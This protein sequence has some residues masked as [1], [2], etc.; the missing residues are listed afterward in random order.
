MKSRF[1]N[2]FNDCIHWE[3]NSVIFLELFSQEHKFEK[4]FD[5]LKIKFPK[6]TYMVLNI[7]PKFKS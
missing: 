6:V 4:C 2:F 1:L 7:F 3:C 5:I